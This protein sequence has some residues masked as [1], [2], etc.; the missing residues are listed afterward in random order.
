MKVHTIL[1]KSTIKRVFFLT[2]LGL[3]LFPGMANAAD[4]IKMGVLS[5]GAY[6]WP[7]FVADGKGFFEDE[8][9][10][11]R[12]FHVRSVSKAVQS[13]SAGST[14]V[15]I[16]ANTSGVIRAQAKNA[17]VKLIA[18]GFNKP[19]YELIAGAKY[20]TVEDL[21]GTTLGVINLTSGSTVLLKL[22]LASHGLHYPKDFDML[23]VGGT[24]DRFAAV[25]RGGVSA[26]VV[27]P[28]TS[29]MALDA[30]LK[31][32][33]NVGTYVPTYLF[34]AVA[35]N[36]NW[37]KKNKGLTVRFLKAII[38]AHRFIVDPKNREEATDIL[39]K[40]SKTDLKYSRLTYK[41]VLE[42]LKPLTRNAEINIKALEAVI[43]IDIENKK[44]KKAY[45][46][47]AFFDDS[48]WKE[49][50]KSLGG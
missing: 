8:G 44:L 32:L 31:V 26:A 10:K 28:P 23:K 5:R 38:R 42:D 9:L 47:S 15:L 45:P 46:A 48:Y 41:M 22:V 43:K 7:W 27:N 37:M 11:I 39:A 35:G 33:A 6:H 36:S 19:L 2:A 17:P 30:G 21:K 14:H 50:L 3:I 24:P 16:P 29:Y 25:K 34:T 12:R 4:E 49:A 18:G 13:L 20:N 40:Y 1:G